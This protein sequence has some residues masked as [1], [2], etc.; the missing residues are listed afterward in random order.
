MS[1]T[2]PVLTIIFLGA[3]ADLCSLN[4]SIFYN[5]HTILILHNFQSSDTNIK[6]LKYGKYLRYAVTLVNRDSSFKII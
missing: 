2:F 5:R 6:I 3:A 4:G 1:N